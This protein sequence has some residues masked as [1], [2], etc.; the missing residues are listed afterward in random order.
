MIMKKILF[1]FNLLLLSTIHSYS[2]EIV[3]E[4]NKRIN[5]ETIKVYGDIKNKNEYS[6]TEINTYLKN[7]Y[8][9]N[10]FEDIQISFK[11]K[12]LK[13]TVKEFPIINA[14]IINGEPSKKIKES[15]LKFMK[16]KEKEGFIES[17]LSFDLANITQAYQSLG[18]LLADIDIQKETLDENSLNLIIEIERG[19]KVKVKKINFIGDKKIK[20]R[21]LR[22]I[23]VT[24]EDKFWKFISK[25]T[26]F[27]KNNIDIDK[28]LLENFYKSVGYYDV[29][30]I[31]SNVTFE[32]GESGIELTYNIDAGSRY[33]ISK[34]STN[35]D[36]S[37]KKEFFVDIKKVFNDYL[38]EYY[39][40]FKIKKVLEELDLIIADNDLQFIEHS[41]NEIINDDQIEVKI[42]IFESQKILVERI[43]II[44]N[45]ITNENVIRSELLL[46]EGDPFS[47]L[48][49][50]QSVAKLKARDIFGKVV[51][52]TSQG[53]STNTRSITVEVEEKPTGEISAGAGI[54]S[55][56]G[57]FAFNVSENNWI[58]K[59]VQLISMVEVDKNSLKGEIGYIDPNYKNSGNLLRYGISSSQND[60]PD[61]GFENSLISANI[62]TKYEQFKNIYFSPGLSITSDKLT[63][64]DTASKNLKKQAGTYTDL[65]LDY[66]FSRDNR[67]RAF[68]PTSGSIAYF[69]QEFPVISDA[70][71]IKN[72]ISYSGYREINE[73]VIGAFKIFGSAING[74]DED[75][76]L[77]KR[78]Y[79]SSRKLRGFQSGKVGPK[80]GIDYIGGNYLTTVNLE[81][82]LPNFLPESTKTEVATFIDIGNV[83]G[84]DY[85]SSVDESN[86]IRSSTGA[87]ASWLSPLGPMTFTYARNIT[88]ASTDKT[89]SFKFQLGT[90]F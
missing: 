34:F 8:E 40:P 53:S 28:R 75:V 27:S 52:D 30:I 31:S 48:K 55:D 89:Q 2:S 86:K 69:S 45:N 29:K 84:V 58:G 13:I 16:S 50:D 65:S 57:S 39:S 60:M 19:E 23:I 79:A 88:K 44:G 41:V 38:G 51:A 72:N 4:G 62:G 82:A 80:D 11:N 43:E 46:D 21:R 90:T 78:L 7:L 1:A 66:A 9:T 49:L 63:V 76:R 24:T 59:G 35:I 36:P 68:M 61:S 56:G 42:N 33:R 85:D 6:N 87:S 83:W 12:I 14:I 71:S 5:K 37:L 64:Q 32:G 17:N 15:V 25:N 67:N 3:V 74:F 47:N 18:Y 70:A 26:I 54:G 10:F 20:E 77:S 81:A 22:D 73:N